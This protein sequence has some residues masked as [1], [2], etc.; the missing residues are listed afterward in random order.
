MEDHTALNHKLRRF[1]IA[2]PACRSFEFYQLGSDDIAV[3]FTVDDDA[4][5]FDGSFYLRRLSND[6]SVS[7]DDFAFVVAVD[8]D[9]SFKA[10][11]S[12]KRALWPQNGMDVGT[13]GCRFRFFF[14]TAMFS[15]LL[16]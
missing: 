14:N 6:E 5:D 8:S 4:S 3:D 1:N 9:S 11:L 16:C 2:V 10:K 7:G 15:I 13:I 12:F